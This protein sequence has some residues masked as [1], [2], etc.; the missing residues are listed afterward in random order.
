MS[1]RPSTHGARQA[2]KAALRAVLRAAGGQ[3]VASDVTRVKQ[4]QLSRYASP[5][6]EN[7]HAPLDVVL[8]LTLE[9]GNTAV[10]QLL[11]R[12][13]GG[14]F[15]PLPDT[16]KTPMIWTKAVFE[17]VGRN[18]TAVDA[19]GRALADDGDVSAQ[20]IREMKIREHLARLL[21]TVVLLD[22]YAEQVLE[23]EETS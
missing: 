4:P 10:L 6:H 5:T 15:V 7:E 23:D 20:E 9:T 21:E 1:F 13:A 8:D 14:V 3:D 11:C 2:L 18:G 17:A 22:R 19:F 16:N 12:Q